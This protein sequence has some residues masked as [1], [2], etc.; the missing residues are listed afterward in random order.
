MRLTK[1]LT[2]ILALMLTLSMVLAGCQVPEGV[3]I[4]SG[5][6]IPSDITEEELAE[7]LPSLEQ[8][9]ASEEA[10][11]EETIEDV[12]V[13]PVPEQDMHEPEA[14]TPE[15]VIT[16]EEITTV[17][18]VTL[19]SG[20]DWVHKILNVEEYRKAYKDL[21]AVYGDDWDGYVDHYLTHGLYEG[22]DEVSFLIP[23]RMR[24]P[25]RM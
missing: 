16:E 9:L 5:V 20:R 2:S 3:E 4:P 10:S 14:V 24:K 8:E 17:S 11:G 19:P 7:L 22:R 23:G 6:S 12:L 25:I 1:R 21:Q 13:E 15:E 18:K